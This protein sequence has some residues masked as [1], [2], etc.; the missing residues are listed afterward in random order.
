MKKLFCLFILVFTFCFVC[1]KHLALAEDAHSPSLC[2]TILPEAEG[3]DTNR[4][5][6][7]AP[8]ASVALRNAL[9]NHEDTVAQETN[10]T[11][12]LRV[13][14]LDGTDDEKALV[15][16]VAPEWSKHANIVFEFVENGN[17]DIRIKFD[18]NGGHWSYVGIQAINHDTTM[19]LALRGE[20]NKEAVILHEFGHALGLMHEH[21]SPVAPIQ[22]N[23]AVVIK[24]MQEGWDWNEQKTRHNILSRLSEEQTNSTEFDRDSIMLYAIPNRWTIGDFETDYN[25]SLSAKDKYF[26]GVLYGIFFPDPNLRAEIENALDLK[27]RAPIS[28]EELQQLTE[29]RATGNQI[30]DLT[31]LEEATQLMRL[32]LDNNE[33]VDI[34]PLSTLTQLTTLWLDDN[35]IVDISPLSTLTQLTTLWL[36]DN[37]IEDIT[38]L[39]GLVNLE[40]L[41]LAENP[42]QDMSSLCQLLARNP[43]LD[44]DIKSQ[45]CDGES[46]KIY[47]VTFDPVTNTESLKSADLDGG[48]PQILLARQ[49]LSMDNL[50]VDSVSNKIYWTANNRVTKIVSLE[51]ADLDGGN[52]RVLH[53]R[54]DTSLY[55]LV[56]DGMRGKIYWIAYDNTGTDRIQCVDSDGGNLQTFLISQGFSVDSLTIDG[57]SSKIYWIANNGVTGMA[58]LES[59]DLDGGNQRVLHTGQ[60]VSLYNLV[61]DGMS[62]KIYWIAYDKVTKMMSLESV[63]LDGGNQRVLHTGQNISLYNLVV[64]GVSSKIYWIAYDKVTKMMS[65][66][67]A[68]LDGGN[69]RVLH[70]G[71]NISLYNLVVDGVSSKIYWIAYDKVTKMMSLESADLDGGNPQTLV[72]STN[73]ISAF[74]VATSLIDIPLGNV[75]VNGDGNVNADD[76]LIVVI[77]LGKKAEL[78]PRADVNQDGNVTVDDLLLVIDNLDDAVNAAAPALGDITNMLPLARLEALLKDLRAE[79]DGSLKYQRAIAFLENLLTTARPEKTLLLANYPNPF[80]P[81][82]WIPYQLTKDGEVSITIY[83]IRGEV[84]RHLELGHQLVGVYQ[85]KSRAAYWDGRNELGESVASG[86]YF[87]TLKAGNFTATRKMLI[88]R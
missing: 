65:L 87:Y 43:N 72:S 14:F 52:Q 78:E 84:V 27:P 34:S 51:S 82:T 81:E 16:R 38:P 44:V 86:V 57:V 66:E 79:S 20:Q 28:P 10:S 15:R 68:D 17:S 6:N 45:N 12:I 35:E 76:L 39:V 85:S 2:L 26:I 70:T 36:D 30:R 7:R 49:D 55:N 13:R 83:D 29:F 77:T 56:V 46:A 59:A 3:E 75:D 19:N 25:T 73:W 8:K 47:W 5:I 61:V 54:R 50:S 40:E 58:S 37:S 22:W 24:E 4:N 69:Q 53:T 64:D 23:E 32:S 62:S 71:Q 74:A 67:S 60:N 42:I 80:N 11:F 18:P 21:K 33:I 1:E 31:G 9:W 88:M 63:D 48:N 41:M